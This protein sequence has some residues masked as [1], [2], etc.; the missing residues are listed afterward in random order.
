MKLIHE[1]LEGVNSSIELKSKEFEDLLTR[2]NELQMNIPS[3]EVNSDSLVELKVAKEEIEIDLKLL[4][5]KKEKLE[6]E[7]KKILKGIKIGN[8][9]FDLFSKS[10]HYFD[11]SLEKITTSRLHLQDNLILIWAAVSFLPKVP[12]QDWLSQIN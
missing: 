4:R 12:A 2:I 11:H 3:E 9:Y 8:D 5:D 1:E 6:P 7:K 10:F